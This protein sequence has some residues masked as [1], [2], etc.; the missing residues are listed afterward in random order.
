ME[1]HSCRW[2]ITIFQHEREHNHYYFTF[3][4]SH[5]GIFKRR[6]MSHKILTSKDLNRNLPAEIFDRAKIYNKDNA[7]EWVFR[8]KRDADKAV[9]TLINA[10][11]NSVRRTR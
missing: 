8:S 3:N 4:F 2:G 11:F 9:G 6:A 5:L 1:S 7:L 10:G